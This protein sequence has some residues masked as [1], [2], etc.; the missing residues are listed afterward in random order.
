ME[1]DETFFFFF[2][3]LLFL[4]YQARFKLKLLTVFG[5]RIT[6]HVTYITSFHMFRSMDFLQLAI[7][8]NGSQDIYKRKIKTSCR[9]LRIG[10]RHFLFHCQL[11]LK[12]L[13]LCLAYNFLRFCW[14]SCSQSTVIAMNYLLI[15][16]TKYTPIVKWITLRL[17]GRERETK[18]G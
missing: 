15:S 17:S 4:I 10:H 18:R 1:I 16:I 5:I 13:S 14:P 8:Y 11:E 7:S 12:C 3:S 2:F 9:I 6:T